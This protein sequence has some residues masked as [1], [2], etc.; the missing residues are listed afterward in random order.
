LNL[1]GVDLVGNASTLFAI[2]ILSPFLIM[3]FWSAAEKKINV[4]DML[5]LPP[6]IDV[7]S[8][9]SCFNIVMW[10]YCGYESL[11]SIIEEVKDP[12]KNF[13]RAMFWLIAMSICTYL[14]AFLGAVSLDT[15]Y[16]NWES[17]WFAV[18]AGDLGGY[19][20]KIVMVIA[21]MV[22]S[23]GTYNAL[24]CTSSQELRALGK[25][26]LLGSRLLRYKHPYFRTPWT[27]IFLNS[28][29]AACF[30]FF[31]FSELVVVNNIIY[32]LML[33]MIFA[34]LIKLRFSHKD[35]VRPY[36]ISKSTV[37]TILA[38]TPPMI[39]SAYIIFSS[40]IQSPLQFAIVATMFTI[41]SVSY[42]LLYCYR[43]R[44][45]QLPIGAA[46]I[47]LDGSKDDSS[48]SD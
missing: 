25:P 6:V 35:M 34:T 29:G 24:L 3:F 43:K 31:S 16:D 26:D 48:D 13:V 19:P 4:S 10:G 22:S 11:G 38:V 9:T 36:R 37:V 42:F 33:L 27:A 41:A 17:G 21:A 46:N 15:N 47:Q 32:S 45:N 23:F 5:E 18:V 20:L 44:T 39:I 1:A 12:N 40:A 28:V 2:L 30:S 8:V 14:I 7:Q